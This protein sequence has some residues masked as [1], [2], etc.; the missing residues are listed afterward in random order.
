MADA[1]ATATASGT[2]VSNVGLAGA[3]DNYL[4]VKGQAGDPDALSAAAKS[5][6]ELVDAWFFRNDQTAGTRCHETGAVILEWL[7]AAATAS[8]SRQDQQRLDAVAE[9]YEMRSGDLIA[10]FNATDSWQ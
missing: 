8:A 2:G 7:S 10:T 3:V 4:S 6:R 5:V 1:D 9:L